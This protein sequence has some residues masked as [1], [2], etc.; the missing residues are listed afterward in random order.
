M[1]GRLVGN[2]DLAAEGK[3]QQAKVATAE[4]AALLAAEA[5]QLERE[6]ELVAEQDANR[7]ERQRVEAE[8]ASI[9]RDE[10]IELEHRDEAAKIE[11]QA[12]K[13][14]AAVDDRARHDE[15]L[16]ENREQDIAMARVEAAVEAAAIT[17]EAKQAEAVAD[18]LGDAQ[19]QL[20]REQNGE[21][22]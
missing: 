6:A 15:K 18:V 1:V 22:S 11:R 12:A 21:S 19:Q 5:E 17:N 2:D 10:Q 3:L 20:E 13:T 9:E 4:D 16:I 7:I 8:L 14:R